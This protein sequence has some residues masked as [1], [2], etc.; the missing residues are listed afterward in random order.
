MDS[1]PLAVLYMF[2]QHDIQT[3]SKAFGK[4]VCI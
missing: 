4:L 3:D 1:T 2:N